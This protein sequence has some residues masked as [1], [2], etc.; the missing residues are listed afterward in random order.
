MFLHIASS[1]QKANAS[2]RLD[3]SKRFSGSTPDL[4]MLVTSAACL[5]DSILFLRKTLMRLIQIQQRS[6]EMG[7]IEAH[8]RNGGNIQAR[9]PLGALL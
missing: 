8:V 1:Y 2:K 4:M 3:R 6:A 5:R 9:A 7:C